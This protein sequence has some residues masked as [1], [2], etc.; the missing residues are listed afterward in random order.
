MGP[1]ALPEGVHVGP[2]ESPLHPKSKS[3]IESV[4]VGAGGVS[5]VLGGAG[6]NDAQNF[7]AWVL[8]GNCATVVPGSIVAHLWPLWHPL[9][10]CKLC[11]SRLW[12]LGAPFGDLQTV[13]L[14][15]LGAFGDLG[16]M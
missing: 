4:R 6:G 5:Y 15:S 10:P 7:G 13:Q 1:D 3:S 2:L 12:R 14:S 8:T 11:H 9:G 16:T